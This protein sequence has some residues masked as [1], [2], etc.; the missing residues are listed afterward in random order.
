MSK[1]KDRIEEIN[2]TV[3]KS[4][5]INNILWV[6]VIVFV[7]TSIYF[8]IDAEISKEKAITKEEEAL[9]AR[10]SL[11]L[12]EE[13]LQGEKNKLEEFKKKYDVLVE[14]KLATNDDLWQY[15]V[16]ANTF[17]AYMDYINVKGEEGISEHEDELN[18]KLN[19]FLNRTGFVQFQESSSNVLFEPMPFGDRDDLFTPKSARSVRKGVIGVDNS[20]GRNGDV[21]LEGQI[22]QV[23]EYIESGNS[24]WAKIRYSNS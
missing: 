21:I 8:A 10:D 13:D 23:V 2:K 14:E 17:E 18:T 7:G 16:E 12:L 4:R 11:K 5:R 20:Y 22:V 24:K 1:L 15:T 6:V 9:A 19:S 3:Q